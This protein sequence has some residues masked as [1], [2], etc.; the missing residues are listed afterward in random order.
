MNEVSESLRACAGGGLEY[1]S[2]YLDRALHPPPTH[3][4][5]VNFSHLWREKVI[6]PAAECQSLG[7]DFN[8][9]TLFDSFC[10]GGFERLR[11]SFFSGN[12]ASPNTDRVWLRRINSVIDLRSLALSEGEGLRSVSLDLIYDN[13]GNMLTWD[14][15]ASSA[16]YT[17]DELN[18]V[19]SMA[20]VYPFG[21]KAV[22]YTYDRF[23]N[24]ETAVYPDGMG[25]LSYSYDFNRLTTIT[26]PLST[27]TYAYDNAGRMLT[28]VLPNGVA[29]SYSYDNANRLT[30][31]TNRRSDSSPIS[32]FIYTHDN[33][34]NRLTM[35]ASDGAHNYA[36]D[37]IYRLLGAL[38]PAAST[39]SYT[40]DRVGNRLTSA[41][42]PSWNY[43]ANNRLQSYDGTTFTYDN[44]GNTTA[45]QDGAALTA[46]TYDY[47]NRLTSVIASASEAI[48]SYDPFGKRLSKTFGGVT[49]YY[50]YDEEDIIAEYDASGTRIASYIHGPGIDEPVQMTRGGATYY[51]TFDGL[52]S[53]RDLTDGSEALVEQ[54]D[55]D[56]FGNLTAPPTT[57]N[58]YTYTAREYDPETGLL[59]YRA[60]YY[61]SKAGRFLTEDPIGFDGGIN[62]YSYTFNDPV[63]WIDPW[64]LARIGRRRLDGRVP[65]NGRGPIRH[66][67]IWYDDGTNSGFFNDDTIRSDRGHTREEYDFT[68]DPRQYDDDLMRDAERNV[69]KDWDMDWR[70]PW[71]PDDWT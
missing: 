27:I 9:P 54:Y 31:L 3:Y 52:G 71:N 69:Q 39:E 59:F 20:I 46:Y 11:E 25:T 2:S 47:E 42:E 29:T 67:N 32:S 64:G 37:N 48:Y 21:S 26:Y 41:A 57:G 61:D 24:R 34:G 50:L 36:Y 58:P 18:R 35:T 55:Y 70:M 49:T 16:T 19:A 68:R 43:D 65:F 30:S 13:A 44:S 53:V 14:D 1:P 7:G 56:S 23:G 38:H 12:P 51:Y 15:G 8:F 62:F 45:K 22:S 66:D 6:P 17:Y 40:Y 28:K 10:A 63:N 33:V 4:L 5:K 60:R